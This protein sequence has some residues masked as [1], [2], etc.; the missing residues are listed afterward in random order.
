[1]NYLGYYGLDW[2][3]MGLSLLA[4]WLIGDKNRWGFLVFICANLLWIPLGF[5]LL[6]SLGILLGNFFFLITNL[7]AFV[8]WNRKES[9]N[10]TL[11]IR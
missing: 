1:M 6:N 4:V 2:L 7:R 8:R 5:T 11:Q 9:E 10:V 3:A